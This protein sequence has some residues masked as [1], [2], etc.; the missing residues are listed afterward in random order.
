MAT[1][2]LVW[3]RVRWGAVG[4]GWTTMEASSYSC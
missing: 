2:V 1:L 4:R 3:G